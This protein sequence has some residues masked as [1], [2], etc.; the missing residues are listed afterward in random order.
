V[1]WIDADGDDSVG[2]VL[3]GLAGE[4]SRP[5]VLVSAP[6]APIVGDHDGNG[7]GMVSVSVAG[8]AVVVA[9]TGRPGGVG[10]VVALALVAADEASFPVPVPGDLLMLFIGQQAAAG[11]IPLWVA[12]VGIAG[13]SAVG[14]TLVFMLARGP[15]RSLIVGLLSRVG[16]RPR[17]WEQVR[18]AVERRGPVVLAVGRATPGARTASVFGSALAGVSVPRALPALVAG[19]V[20]F[21][22][23]HVL[24]GYALGDAA[25]R[26]TS[27]ATPYLI[28]GAGVL[29]VFAVVW[30]VKTRQATAVKDGICPI[31]VA[32][33]RL[34]PGLGELHDGRDP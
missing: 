22:E 18:A 26:V 23:A 31:C 34:Q 6:V 2:A 24:L 7:R 8:A 3:D 33:A 12:V 25:A 29:A 21:V 17:R 20:V 13:A 10:P 14:T 11:S 30:L 32:V 5:K 4:T 28:V 16:L 19:S 1:G 15:A 27:Q 9:A